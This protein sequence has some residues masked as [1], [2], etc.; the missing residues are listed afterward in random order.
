MIG[1]HSNRFFSISGAL[2]RRTG[3]LARFGHRAPPAAIPVLARRAGEALLRTRVQRIVPLLR[4]VFS[5]AL[6]RF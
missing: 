5:F 6:K 4:K 3:E 1:V 2:R